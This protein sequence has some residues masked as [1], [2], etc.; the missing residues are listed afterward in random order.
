MSKPWKVRMCWKGRKTKDRSCPRNSSSQEIILHHVCERHLFKKPGL[1]L[2][3]N[4]YPGHQIKRLMVKFLRVN[5]QRINTTF[6]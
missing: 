2:K 1:V 3:L 4:I 5:L 6:F